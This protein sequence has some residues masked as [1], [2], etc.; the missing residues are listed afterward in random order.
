[1]QSQRPS[2]RTRIAAISLAVAALAAPAAQARPALDPPAG[3][4]GAASA[5]QR[6]ALVVTSTPDSGFDWGSAGIGA[7]AGAGLVLVGGGQLRAEPP[8]PREARSLRLAPRLPAMRARATIGA[9]QQASSSAART[10]SRASPRCSAIRGPAGH[11]HGPGGRG[12][13]APGAGRG[14]GGRAR[15]GGRPR[16]CRSR[17]ARGRAR[18]WPRRSRPPPAPARRPGRRR[19]TRPWRRW[20]TSAPCSCSTTSSTS[21]SPPPTS[22]PCSTRVRG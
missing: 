14:R 13:D 8:R 20:A 4:Q 2:R 6:S 9:C 18:W 12:Q 7:A 17:P 21:R 19:W 11:R 16:P 5:P 3:H 10:T 15:P 1:M 22:A